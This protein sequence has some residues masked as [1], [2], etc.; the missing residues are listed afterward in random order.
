MEVEGLGVKNLERLC[1]SIITKD[2]KVIE[3]KVTNGSN[4]NRRSFLTPT[5]PADVAFVI[6]EY[7]Q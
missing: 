1:E 4:K 6:I 7:L 3:S 2:D 5:L